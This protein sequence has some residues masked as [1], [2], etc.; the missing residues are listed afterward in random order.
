MGKPVV[1]AFCLVIIIIILS[2]GVFVMFGNALINPFV[3]GDSN[4][5][6]YAFTVDQLGNIFFIRKEGVAQSL[7]VLDSTGEQWLRTDI[8]PY[9]GAE[10]FIDR[11]YILQNKN[12]WVIGYEYEPETQMIGNLKIAAFREDGSFLENIFSGER[13]VFRDSLYQMVSSPDEDD[14]H[15]Y[16]AG[17]GAEE[18]A[19]DIYVHIKDTVDEPVRKIG[20]H[21]PRLAPG[22]NITAMHALPGGGLVISASDGTLAMYGIG[23]TEEILGEGS[24]FNN[25]RIDRFWNGAGVFYMRDAANGTIYSSSIGQLRPIAVIAGT[26]IVSAERE[27]AFR[28]MHDIAVSG[29]GNVLGVLRTEIG[30]ELYLGGFTFLPRITS[31]SSHRQA[32]LGDWFALIAAIAGIIIA[33]I[34][35]WEFFVHFMRMRMPM[36]MREILLTAL[37]VFI[38][39]FILSEY[40]LIPAVGES[41]RRSYRENIR[42]NADVLLSSLK[43]SVAPGSSALEYDRFM[44]RF[45]EQYNLDE[46]NNSPMFA[47]LIALGDGRLSLAASGGKYP[48]GILISTFL[49]YHEIINEIYDSAAAH[50]DDAEGW[51]TTLSTE[52]GE[53]I[54]H[55]AP[56][57]ITVDGERTVLCVI[58]N[59]SE[60][61]S[62]IRSFAEMVNNFLL[63][64]GVLLSLLIILSTVFHVITLKKLSKALHDFGL[65]WYESVPE[66]SSGDETGELYRHIKKLAEIL[67]EN[68]N[69][70][71][72]LSM[73]YHR[74]VPERFLKLLGETRVDK[75]EKDLQTR[76]EGAYVV[77]I[78]F[79]ISGVQDV[80]FFESANL[81]LEN[82]VPLVSQY[83]G[84]VYNFLYNGFDGVFEGS[85]SSAVDAALSIRDVC[86]KFNNY[87]AEKTGI[88]VDLR[89]VLT[90]GDLTLG[91]MGDKT[92]MEPT[93]ISDTYT[94]A[95]TLVRN[96]FGSD[97]YV[98]ATGEL[99][100]EIIGE[101]Y[102]MRRV[103]TM[104]AGD[105]GKTVD[106]YDIYDSDPLSLFE[107]K[108]SFSDKFDVG[109][110][111]FSK[112]D[113]RKAYAMFMDII[114]HS[115]ED[116]VARNYLYL[117]EYNL[118]NA[119]KQ[120]YYSAF[121]NESAQQYFSKISDTYYSNA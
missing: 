16:F 101:D 79:G 77:F 120:P 94:L 61:D 28:D 58:V 108:K 5:W 37:V 24:G 119:D 111:L 38:A 26:F 9:F 113:Y 64:L 67:K 43:T 93:A 10:F 41:L 27:A 116:G 44:E 2:T 68:D 83:G 50:D 7:I 56:T 65:G 17:P 21:T 42:S 86:R 96:C 22:A 36:V 102:N 114:K 115:A 57:D 66:I 48:P 103:G 92:R 46:R 82:I 75:V 31:L 29:V 105:E 14:R 53:M 23:G 91:F 69:S 89:V 39:F 109:V 76:I 87:H 45:G 99:Y 85:A 110:S 32:D 90:K 81:V 20:E 71:Q 12:I 40:L 60:L 49:P 72:T 112:G 34:L 11:L 30:S 118:R 88:E 106:F 63:I 78:R 47:Y 1:K 55:I 84:T 3:Q 100:A 97:I 25:R 62:S 104:S 13:S 8:T 19:I 51:Y 70:L 95:E 73:S 6:D 121:K 117:S 15:V 18:G 54:A 35:I 33:S 80:D 4:I 74:F 59:A 107:L 52:F 98:A